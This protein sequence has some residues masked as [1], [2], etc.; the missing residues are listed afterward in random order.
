LEQALVNF[1]PFGSRG[2]G[3]YRQLTDERMTPAQRA[4]KTA[5]NFLAGAKLADEDLDRSK[6]KAAREMLNTILTNTP[7]VQTYEN[8]AI[9]EE[10]LLAMPKDQQDLYLL[11]RV[12][13]S[14]A[15]KRARDKKKQ[16]AMDPLELL[17][18]VNG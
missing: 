13:Q 9:P 18:L 16:A 4:Q 10:D 7:G 8:L 17:G 11:Y 2:L 12:L 5:F 1:M 14:E 15:A 3:M 6:R